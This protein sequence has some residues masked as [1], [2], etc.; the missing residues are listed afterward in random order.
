MYRAYRAYGD[1][2]AR[3]KLY[4]DTCGFKGNLQSRNGVVLV[5][6]A[7]YL[8]IVHTH[9]IMIRSVIPKFSY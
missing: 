3:F 5:E 7:W 9:A 2:M 1:G 4:L 6:P 8:C